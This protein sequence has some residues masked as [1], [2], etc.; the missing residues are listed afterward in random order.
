MA[1]CGKLYGII[2]RNP[3]QVIERL[4]GP[5][6][7]ITDADSGK[8]GHQVR[9]STGA[10]LIQVKATVGDGESALTYRLWVTRAHGTGPDESA[11][12]SATLTPLHRKGSPNRSSYCRV[13]CG[14]NR[15]T[16]IGSLTDTAFEIPGGDGTPYTID[17]IRGVQKLHLGFDTAMRETGWTKLTLRVRSRPVCL[18]HG[19]GDR[20]AGRLVRP[21]K[22]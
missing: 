4:F 18:P 13:I 1:V 20:C 9:L 19:C 12:G 14:Q 15:Y 22:G 16:P 2:V 10:N 21:G 7:P 6:S 17:S 8:A 3:T 11:V 5:G